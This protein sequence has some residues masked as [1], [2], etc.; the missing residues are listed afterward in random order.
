M[1]RQ[2]RLF[3]GE[4]WQ[5]R[6]LDAYDAILRTWPVP[7]RS[8]LVETR[9]GPTHVIS[10]GPE[11]GPPIVLR[12]G[13]GV[14]STMWRPNFEALSERHAVHAV[15]TLWEV[16]KGA[17]A[18]FPQS[19][20]EANQWLVDVLD[21]LGLERVDLVGLSY[22]GF[23]SLRFALDVPDRVRRLVILAPA[24]S[25]SDLSG[26]FMINALGSII[27][28]TRPERICRALTRW[29]AETPIDEDLLVQWIAGLRGVRIPA[30]IQKVP[31]LVL[32]D[33][34]LESLRPETLLLM[35]EKEWTCRDPRGGMERF[36]RLVPQGRA[37]M[38]DGAGHIVSMDRPDEVHAR[39][40]AH[41]D[42][43]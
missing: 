32:T 15:D 18:S 7:H 2:P 19:H 26:K 22:G 40:L 17:P 41:L 9:F 29:A 31:P 5:R 3:R 1:A 21:G 35:G 8:H 25:L 10:S 20:A 4:R 16:G 13:A 28:P 37:E 43:A 33:E 24:A 11:D 30:P 14:S 12:H 6:Y 27:I 23:L 38:L 36:R 39:I 34:E 42:A